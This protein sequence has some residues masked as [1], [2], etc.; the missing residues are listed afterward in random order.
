MEEQVKRWK[1]QIPYQS[2][3]GTLLLEV[4]MRVPRE[5]PV[6][7]APIPASPCFIL[8]L[9]LLFSSSVQSRE[10]LTGQQGRNRFSRYFWDINT[11]AIPQG[12]ERADGSPQ[13]SQINRRKKKIQILLQRSWIP[14]PSLSYPSA[15]TW[16]FWSLNVFPTGHRTP[17]ISQPAERCLH[18]LDGAGSASSSR[19]RSRIMSPTAF[20]YP[21]GTIS[22]GKNRLL[23]AQHPPRAALR[24]GCY[25]CFLTYETTERSP[26][27][28]ENDTLPVS[29]ALLRAQRPV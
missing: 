22:R 1:R 11:G 12:G 29:N 19:D 21:S 23:S 28:A 6:G 4:S 13:R 17:E 26:N 24:P 8:L 25:R 10:L 20:G 27:E 3:A 18:L 9:L 7:S 16:R 15:V 5:T 14:P 2:I